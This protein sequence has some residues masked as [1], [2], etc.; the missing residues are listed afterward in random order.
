MPAQPTPRKA[1]EA[2]SSAFKKE[3]ADGHG[4]LD[5]AFYALR[6]LQVR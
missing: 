3:I 5:A 6:Q 1:V 4:D 2:V